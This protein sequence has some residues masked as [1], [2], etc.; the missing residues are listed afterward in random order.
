[1]FIQI[2]EDGF[3]ATIDNEAEFDYLIER[4]FFDDS[5]DDDTLDIRDDDDDDDEP[6]EWEE[7]EPGKVNVDIFSLNP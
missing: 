6:Q 4:M 7:F 5:D 2:C 3:V 1:M